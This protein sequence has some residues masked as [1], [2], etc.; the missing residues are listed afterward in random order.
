MENRLTQGK[1]YSIPFVNPYTEKGPYF[2]SISAIA[3]NETLSIYGDFDIR[4]TFFDNVGIKTYL[5][6]V[7]DTTDIYICHPINGTDPIEVD[8]GTFIFIPTTIIDYNNV[9]EYFTSVK[10]SFSLE[11]TQ[12]RFETTSEKNSF[13]NSLYNEIPIAMNNINL[14]ANDVLSMSHTESELLLSKTSIENDE[15]SREAVIGE[16]IKLENMQR[17][18]ITNR[19]MDYYR[20]INELSKNEKKVQELYDK[21]TTLISTAN[22]SVTYANNF[23]EKVEII[24]ANLKKVYDDVKKQADSIGMVIDSWEDIYD[25]NTIGNPSETELKDL[26]NDYNSTLGSV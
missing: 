10:Y 15:K 23:L 16:R 26:L 22:N 9:E 6:M 3:R 25:R 13:I 17:I 21:Y 20:R 12:R 19:E 11:G 7:T 8:T 24:E 14:L 2:V 1:Y 4:G 18:N 5:E